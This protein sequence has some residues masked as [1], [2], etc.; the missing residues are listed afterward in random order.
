MY[1]LVRL[2]RRIVFILTSIFPSNKE[3]VVLTI[4]ID[5]LW[6]QFSEFTD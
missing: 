5:S 2:Q 3:L 6:K 4:L 1:G